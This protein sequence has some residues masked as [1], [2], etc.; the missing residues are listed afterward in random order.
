MNKTVLIVGGAGYIG[1]HTAYLLHKSGYQVIILDN[2]IHQQPFYITWATVVQGD[3]ADE[4]ILN[5]IFFRYQID[6][7]MHFAA[8]IEVGESV[9]KPQQFFENNVVK[10][11]ALLNVMNRHHVKKIVF[12]S[13]CAVYG[14]PQYIPLDEKHVLAPINPYGKNKL[15]VEFMLQDYAAA[16]NLH[17]VVLR[18]FNAAGAD[19]KNGLGEWHNPETHVLPI[20]LRAVLDNRPFYIFGSDYKTSD[21]T[22]IR[23]YIHVLDIARAHLLAYKY[24]CQNNQSNYFN[25]GSGIGYTV[26]QLI[27]TVEDVCNKK[28]TVSIHSP[29]AGDVPILVADFK[30]AYAVLGWQPQI[31]NL[32]AII[33]SAYAWECMRIKKERER[34]KITQKTQSI[35]C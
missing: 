4:Y 16:Y 17:Y 35:S 29:R 12:S 13:S 7:V 3:F 32:K 2:F 33:E 1:S 26:Q 5:A 30:K 31:S 20:L 23:D 24:L 19:V 34:D 22:C 28:V 18:Y 27:K 15:T 11:F 14:I 21:G 8:F 6:V 9:K 10:T 25:L